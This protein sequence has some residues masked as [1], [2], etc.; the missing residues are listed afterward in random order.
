MKRNEKQWDARVSS[1]LDESIPNM[2]AA[3]QTSEYL[4]LKSFHL[5]SAHF[6]MN[7]VDVDNGPLQ[8]I[9]HDAVHHTSATR[10][11]C[12]ARKK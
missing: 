11:L 9:A 6:H 10:A 7:D 4:V 12:V 2:F 3:I 5:P 1:H 8:L